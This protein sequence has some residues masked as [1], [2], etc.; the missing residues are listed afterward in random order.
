MKRVLRFLF[1]LTLL[2]IAAQTAHAQSDPG[3]GDFVTTHGARIYFEQHGEGEP[4]L[5]LHAFGWTGA[6]WD[7]YLQALATHYRVIVPDLPGH[8][9]STYPD[10][11]GVWRIDVVARQMIGLL[12]ALGL[13][14]VR[15]LG[16]S[17]GGV[18]LLNAATMAPDRFEAIAIVG[19]TPY[20]SAATRD[21]ILENAPVGAE[22]DSGSVAMHGAERAAL[23][24]RQFRNL[25]AYYG[26][27]QLTPD[28][29]NR[30]AAR[31][32]IV[33]GD[34]DALIPVS[35]AWEMYQHIPGAHLWVIPN[36]GHV[37]YR[38]P[39][40]ETIF[41]QRILEFLGGAWE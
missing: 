18:V 32:L 1:G 19:G 2:S 13:G 33:H 23:L 6:S 37:P 41:T 20:R 16:G 7:R 17:A 22:P 25:G 5:L 31:T 21:W 9:R 4:L 36:G 8:G 24:E 3:D 38:D 28:L 27:H 11:S 15:A 10:T 30:I 29:L 40:N 26:D 39:A 14:Q 12:D 35:L 34:N